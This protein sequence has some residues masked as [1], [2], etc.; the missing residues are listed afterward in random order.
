MAFLIARPTFHSTQHVSGPGTARSANLETT[1]TECDS[2]DLQVSSNSALFFRLG[3]YTELARTQFKDIVLYAL[4]DGLP[5]LLF[6]GN[7]HV[8][9]GATS[10]LGVP[11]KK[12]GR[13]GSSTSFIPL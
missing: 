10:G 12:G 13:T 8:F 1:G 3:T 6:L 9:D 5:C 11:L 7:R 4:K 2:D